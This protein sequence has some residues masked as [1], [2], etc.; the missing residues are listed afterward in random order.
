MSPGAGEADGGGGVG[1]P[2][3]RAAIRSCGG[4]AIRAG[5]RSGT[6]A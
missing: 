3:A 2:T 4:R 1:D 6:A 5:G